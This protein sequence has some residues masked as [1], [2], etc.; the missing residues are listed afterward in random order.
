MQPEDSKAQL[1]DAAKGLFAR[2]GLEGATVREIAA[3]A[4]A[5]LCLVSYH[6]GG[7]EGLY[8]AC[9]E[10]FGKARLELARKILVPAGTAQDVRERVG[11][12]VD[13]YLDSVAEDPEIHR[14]IQREVEAGLPIAKDVY[15]RTFL[16][17][18]RALHGFFEAAQEK[19]ILRRD[20][21]AF[22]LVAMVHGTITQLMRMEPIGKQYFHR[23]FSDRKERARHAKTLI[24]VLLDGALSS[25]K[26]GH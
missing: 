14:L 6:F 19:G 17:L 9:L 2:H 4:N 22:T 3:K 12:L 23:A 18:L 25:R 24:G 7:K 21:D 26:E 15:E 20:L 16:K 5:S 8:R 11:R 10:E 1:L 13:L